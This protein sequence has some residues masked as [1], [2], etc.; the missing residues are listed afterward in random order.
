[1]HAQRGLSGSSAGTFERGLL[2]R[3]AADELREFAVVDIE[4]AILHHERGKLLLRVGDAGWQ[5]GQMPGIGPAIPMRRKGP[6][7][8]MVV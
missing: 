3:D 7:F 2:V 6:H 1:V 4:T 8:G 5:R